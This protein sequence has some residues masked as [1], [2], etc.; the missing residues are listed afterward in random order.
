MI[1]DKEIDE[2]SYQTRINIRFFQIIKIDNTIVINLV[3][4]LQLQI[5][6]KL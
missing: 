2:I 4:I 1:I 5:K 6:K 3:I